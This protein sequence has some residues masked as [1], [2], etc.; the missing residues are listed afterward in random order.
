MDSAV[1]KVSDYCDLFL[2]LT[3]PRDLATLNESLLATCL[4]LFPEQQFWLC[5]YNDIDQK[6]FSVIPSGASDSEEIPFLD[7]LKKIV[8]QSSSSLH[9]HKYAIEGDISLYAYNIFHSVSGFLVTNRPIDKA[10]FHEVLLK[11]LK[12]YS[13]QRFF[14]YSALNDALTGL[15]NRQSFDQQI[16]KLLL[17]KQYAKRR[18]SDK[19]NHN[20][21]FALLDIDHFKQVNDDYGHLF[22]DEVLIIFARMMQQTFRNGDLLFR[23]GGEEFAVALR[24]ISLESA[25]SVLNRFRQA[26]SEAEF[27]QLGQVT[28]SIGVTEIEESLSVPVLI[29]RAD[30]ALYFAKE[31]GRNQVHSFEAL[32]GSGYVTLTNTHEGDIELF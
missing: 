22:G 15:N 16:G 17:D 20:W 1:T 11:L 12:V 31:H 8:K 26:V 25:L 5:D 9:E 10:L 30:Q 3:E 14:M 23:Y 19:Q 7:E 21:C 13:N 24:D 18:S 29:D 32:A 6:T 2:A 4:V 27:P 28:V